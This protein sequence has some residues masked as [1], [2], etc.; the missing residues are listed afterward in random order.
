MEVC[1]INANTSPASAFGGAVVD[2]LDYASSTKNTTARALGGHIDNADGSRIYLSSGLMVSTSA[3][4]GLVF[5]GGSGG[6]FVTGS[7]FSLY[8]IKG[9]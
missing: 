3:V 5:Y 4:S 2:I 8:G 1:R 7:R 6:N 9:A